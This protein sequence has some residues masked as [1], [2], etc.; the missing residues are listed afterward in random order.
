[1]TGPVSDR[2]RELLSAL[3][4]GRLSAQERTRL[5]TEGSLHQPGWQQNG[6][7]SGTCGY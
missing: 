3:L 6:N 1:M 4:D 2:D 5:G 7:S